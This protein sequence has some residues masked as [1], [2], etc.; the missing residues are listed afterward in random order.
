[1][2]TLL[3]YWY[4]SVGQFALQEMGKGDTVGH[5][6]SVAGSVGIVSSVKGGTVCDSG[7]PYHSDTARTFLVKP[8]VLTSERFL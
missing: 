2:T 3:V 6:H 8:G 1:M 4:G 5:P 7:S